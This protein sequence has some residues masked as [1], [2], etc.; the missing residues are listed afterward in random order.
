M[1]FDE[2]WRLDRYDSSKSHAKIVYVQ[3]QQLLHH[4]STKYILQL[5]K[6]LGDI[7]SGIDFL[8][9]KLRT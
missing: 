2:D 5:I 4:H 9:S 8:K 6:Y 3:K 7:S 1:Q